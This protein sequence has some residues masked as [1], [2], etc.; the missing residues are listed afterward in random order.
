VDTHPIHRPSCGEPLEILIDPSVRKQA[1]I[2]DC[3][4][5]CRR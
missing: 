1:Y 3:E 5:C 2:E 4:V